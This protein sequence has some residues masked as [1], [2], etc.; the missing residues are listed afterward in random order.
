MQGFK[1]YLENR[2]L[3]F[4]NIRWHLR[5][6]DY[7][8]RFL[9]DREKTLET[10]T[11]KDVLD[12]LKY[13]YRPLKRPSTKT[14]KRELT[15]AT[16]SNI[17]RAINH[18]YTYR[19]KED[20]LKNIACFIKLNNPK[21]KKLTPLFST[22]EL[23][24]LCDKLYQI[25]GLSKHYIAL[26]ILV[27]QGLTKKELARL[28]VD[29]FNLHKA[30]LTI[31]SGIKGNRRVLS[32]HVTQIGSLMFYFQSNQCIITYRQLD[33]LNSVLKT[34]SSKYQNLT[35]LRASVITQ[36]IKTHG[37]RKAQYLAG[38]RRIHTTEAYLHNDIEHL[39]HDISRFHPLG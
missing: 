30:Q 37:L 11:T 17:L 14:V 16:K 12:Y 28:E 33:Q 1:E 22:E 19:S 5:E 2:T 18:Y 9:N 32:L 31:H 3:S 21:K 4:K 23:E 6:L 36:W 20:N 8:Q 7:Y 35:Q 26:S 25:E 13:P 29:D 15:T 10:A 24:Q 38:H 27:Y 34:M 39:Q